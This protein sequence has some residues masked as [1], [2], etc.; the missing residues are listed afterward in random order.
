MPIIL[1]KLKE[2]E[3]K[4]K[5]WLSDEKNHQSNIP[6][7]KSAQRPQSGQNSSWHG[8]IGSWQK[9]PAGLS[10]EKP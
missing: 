1:Q 10:Q 9:F 6:W 8:K 5:K 2:N 7:W 3:P 4:Y